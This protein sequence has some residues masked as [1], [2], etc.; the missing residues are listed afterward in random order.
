MKRNETNCYIYDKQNLLYMK[1]LSM[2]GQVHR[3][4][5]GLSMMELI[6]K[7]KLEQNKKELSHKME[8]EQNKMVRIHKKLG[9]IR[10]KQQ[11]AEKKNSFLYCEYLF[12]FRMVLTLY[13]GAGAE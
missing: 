7:T 2:M 4:Q 6:R 9:L 3:K 11:L 8:L 12:K 1:E 5:L 13:D 10:K